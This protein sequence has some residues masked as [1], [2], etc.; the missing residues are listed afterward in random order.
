MV[1][2]GAAS[3]SKAVAFLLLCGAA[4]AGGDDGDDFSVRAL[5][6]LPYAYL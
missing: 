1:R 6:I 5:S 4:V 3:R 2:Y